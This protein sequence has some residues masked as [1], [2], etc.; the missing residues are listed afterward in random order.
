MAFPNYDHTKIFNS[1]NDKNIKKISFNLEDFTIR[2]ELLIKKIEK[3]SSNFL[4]VWK[5]KRYEK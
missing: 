3:N 2:I 4:L 1:L 5:P